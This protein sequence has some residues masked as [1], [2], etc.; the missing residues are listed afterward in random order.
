MSG[1]LRGHLLLPAGPLPAQAAR[2]RVE[3]RDVG[4]QDA[5][6]PL[7]AAAQWQNVDLAGGRVA[8]RV[9]DVPDLTGRQVAVQVHVD[10]DGSGQITPG[11]LLTTR[12]VP[13]TDLRADV[14]VPL[15]RV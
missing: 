12:H 9:P 4:V 7:L 5:P 1:T 14:D 11:D 10:L 8:Y 15:T 13:V 2:V 3:L 6:A